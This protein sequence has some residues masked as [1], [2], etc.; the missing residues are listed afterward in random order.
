MA[1]TAVHANPPAD[2][3][4]G[5]LRAVIASISP[6]L[7]NRDRWGFQTLRDTFSIDETSHL[8]CGASPDAAAST[9]HE[10]G[11]RIV[12]SGAP[13]DFLGGNRLRFRRRARTLPDRVEGVLRLA[14]DPA[15]AP[16]P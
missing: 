3:Y 16:I 10:A 12:D 13:D 8:Y 7:L 14:I 2:A 11:R 9:I 5:G 6:A 4:L 15:T 1:L